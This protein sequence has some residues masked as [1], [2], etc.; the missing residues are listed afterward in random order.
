[1]CLIYYSSCHILLIHFSLQVRAAFKSYCLGNFFWKAFKFSECECEESSVSVTVLSVSVSWWN[2]YENEIYR[3]W[4][5][6]DGV[7]VSVRRWS[8]SDSV[9]LGDSSL[10]SSTIV[11][12]FESHS[13]TTRNIGSFARASLWV[14][15]SSG[16]WEDRGWSIVDQQ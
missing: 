13:T 6:C 16:T 11:V 5:E 8:E 4:C 14:M 3:A 7:S 12:W 10:W 2:E 1:M 15:I 9:V